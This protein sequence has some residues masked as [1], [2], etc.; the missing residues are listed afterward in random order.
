MGLAADLPQPAQPVSQIRDPERFRHHQSGRDDH[1]RIL[2]LLQVIFFIPLMNLP[3]G[4][5]T[6]VVFFGCLGGP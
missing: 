4:E 3:I 2:A 6:G 5:I 1:P